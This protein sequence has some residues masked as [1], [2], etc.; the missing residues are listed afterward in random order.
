MQSVMVIVVGRLA[1]CVN[2]SCRNSVSKEEI[3]FFRNSVEVVELLRCDQVTALVG[4]AK[5]HV[6]VRMSPHLIPPGIG[7]NSF[8]D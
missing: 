2:R 7:H 6:S 1:A 5:G 4:L 3:D 8:G